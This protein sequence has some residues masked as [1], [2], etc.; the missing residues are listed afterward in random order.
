[1]EQGDS[2]MNAEKIE[3]A[4]N[5]LSDCI[6]TFNCEG[7][8][9]LSM[10]LF[11]RLT[12]I[13]DLFDKAIDAAEQPTTMEN[14]PMPQRADLRGDRMRDIEYEIAERDY[15]KRLAIWRARQFPTELLE[16]G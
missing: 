11:E 8:D 12:E 3:E 4:R 7:V 1:M 5:E 13:L 14:D 15:Q 6:H 9:A 10:P 2:I 16:G